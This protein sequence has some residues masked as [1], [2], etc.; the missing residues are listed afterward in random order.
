M[1][2]YEWGLR[3]LEP[4][5]QADRQARGRLWGRFREKEAVRERY[6]FLQGRVSVAQIREFEVL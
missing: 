5:G 3:T 6:N 1:E 4:L 2:L